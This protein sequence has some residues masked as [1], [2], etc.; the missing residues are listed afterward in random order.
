M[1]I[2]YSVPSAETKAP[3]LHMLMARCY[4]EE[5]IVSPKFVI[6]FFFTDIKHNRKIDKNLMI[7]QQETSYQIKMKLT[8]VQC[9]II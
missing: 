8:Y 7:K 6:L 4:S 3:G 9:I 5:N 2:W 1:Y